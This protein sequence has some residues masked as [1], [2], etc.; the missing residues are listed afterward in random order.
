[1]TVDRREE[2]KDRGI[3]PRFLA[4]NRYV[5]GQWR[6]EGQDDGFLGGLEARN[7]RRKREFTTDVS[8][9][10]TENNLNRAKATVPARPAAGA[11]GVHCHLRQKTPW[12]RPV[13]QGMVFAAARRRSGG[14]AKVTLLRVQ[15][16]GLPVRLDP[17]QWWELYRGQTVRRD[18]RREPRTDALLAG[19]GNS[20]GAV[21]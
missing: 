20:L 7:R 15:A 6:T 17:T 4:K 10:E 19:V 12:W 8:S 13:V 21:R 18:V 5:R 14:A 3:S 9:F 11:P 16:A 1:M 2:R